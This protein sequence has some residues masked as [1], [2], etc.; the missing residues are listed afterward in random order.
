MRT[1]T[2]AVYFSLLTWPITYDYYHLLDL[3]DYTNLPGEHRMRS[4]LDR[5]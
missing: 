3:L 4:D 1:T 2:S 5:A